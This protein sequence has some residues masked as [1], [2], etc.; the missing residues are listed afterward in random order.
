MGS[1][2]EVLQLSPEEDEE[3]SLYAVQLVMAM[4]LPMTLKAAIE[5]RLLEIIVKAGP[6][7]KLSAVDVASQ[8]PTQNPQAADMVDRMLRILAAYRIVSCTAEPGAAGQLLRKYGA[9][10]VCK[11]LTENEDGVSMAP[12]CLFGLDKVMIDFWYYLK[13][14]VLEGGTCFHK[15]YGMTAFEYNGTDPRFNKLFNECMRSHSS[16]ITKKLLD[17][18]CGFD[19]VK[20]LVD[21]GGGTGAALH[22]ITSR[23]P[24]IKGINF[25]LP[26]VI[27]EAP[28]FP[29]GVEHVSGDMF[30]SVPQSDTIF[31]KWILHDWNDEQC[32]KLLKN[33]WKALPEKGKLIV[34]E[35]VLPL[36]PEPNLN[37]RGAFHLDINM[38]V[39]LGGKERTQKEFEALALE[40]G[41]SGFTSTYISMYTWVIEFKK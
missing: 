6:G 32:S 29:A 33:C 8:L 11:H 24:Q 27:S 23:H 39:F 10:P 13:D 22:M 25:D 21:V 2:T 14:A 26:H 18:Y 19:D 4:A 7:A 9:A 40:A 20:V 35:Y 5:L 36:L 1:N 28:S 12:L 38:M 3:A 15:A 37:L 17:I 41:F 31:M 16:I 34:V 30:V